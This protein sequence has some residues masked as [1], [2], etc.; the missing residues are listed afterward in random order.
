MSG[1]EFRIN[2]IWICA[3]L[4]AAIGFFIVHLGWVDIIVWHPWRF[5]RFNYNPWFVYYQ[6][7]STY[8]LLNFLM[9]LFWALLGFIIGNIWQHRVDINAEIKQIREDMELGHK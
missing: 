2:R 5:G 3:A 6:S 8:K 7:S 4:G 1:I 9:L